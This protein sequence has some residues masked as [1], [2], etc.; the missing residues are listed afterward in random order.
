MT[1]CW[2]TNG[3]RHVARIRLEPTAL[4]CD[5]HT[6]ITEILTIQKED[7]WAQDGS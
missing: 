3:A 6:Q 1:E 2:Y 5:I 7:N 4:L